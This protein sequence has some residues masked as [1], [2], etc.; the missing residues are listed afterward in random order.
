MTA[1]LAASIARAAIAAVDL[2]ARVTAALRSSSSVRE[3]RSIRVVAV[4]KAAPA[5]TL[6]ALDALDALG[7]RASRVRVLTADGTDASALEGRHDDLVVLR[8]AHPVPDARSVAGGDALLASVAGLGVEDLVVALI[9]GGAS[10][11]ASAP[12]VGLGREIERG[13]SDALL[14]SGAPVTDVNVVRRHLSRIRGGGLARAALPAR[15]CTLVASDVLVTRDGR[16]EPGA[17]WDVGSGPATP[18]PTGVDDASAILA[19]FAPEWSPRVQRF[20]ATTFP[21]DAPGA[22]RVEST[23]V[24]SPF[25]LAASAL[26]RARAAGRSA[27]PLP[28]SLASVDEL[29]AEYVELARSL[30]KGS[31]RVRVAEPSVRVPHDHGRGGRAGRLALLAWASRGGRALP[32]DV[33]LACVASDG[34]DGGSGSAGA[35]VAGS[36]APD[37][38]VAARRALDA[39]DDASF[40]AGRGAHVTSAPTGTNL[41]DLH[42]LVRA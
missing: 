9:S 8:G 6:G 29:A 33:A 37:D 22:E 38:L 24:A 11:R 16:V 26:E 1:R 13:V 23:I 12:P 25:D 4:G 40:L 42:V 7:A 2:R 36:L 19:R 32:A 3:A 41:L 20:L 5:M 17:P 28:A 30:P 27:A 18:D 39:F 14:R 31:A 10:S 21:A 15:T 35:V 34:V